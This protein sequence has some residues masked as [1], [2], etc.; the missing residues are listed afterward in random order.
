MQESWSHDG[1]DASTKFAQNSCTMPALAATP[2]RIALD[3]RSPA[4]IYR[5]IYGRIRGA[6]LSGALPAGARLPSWN[7]LASE[8]GVARGTVRAAYDWLAGEG[9]IRAEG[10]AGT[11]VNLGFGPGAREAA[12]KRR[13]AG[14]GARK[15]GAPRDA[16][17]LAPWGLPPRPF[18]VGMPALDAFPRD[19]WTRLL[20]RHAR[21]LAPSMMAYPDPAGDPALREAI[22]SYLAVAR[23][24][25]CARGQ[26]FITAGYTGALDLITRALL[27]P[28]DAAW[29]EDPGYPRGRDALKLAGASLV[30]VPVDAEGLIVTRGIAAAP[31]ARF[32]VVTASHHAPL[33]MP[34]SLSR[35]LALLGWASES[36]GWIIED[37]YYGE[38]QFRGR[39]VPA[40]KSLDRGD[41]V[42]YVGTFSKVLMP[43][44]RLGY[45][46]APAALADRLRR[47]ASLLVP[48]Q[49]L[50]AQRAV[51][52]FLAEGH[53]ARHIR[54]MRRIYAERRAALVEALGAEFGS[55]WEIGLQESGMHLLAHLPWGSDD[56]ALVERAA[57]EGLGPVALSPW[58]IR[59]RPRPGLLIGFA[60]IPAARAARETARLAAALRSGRGPR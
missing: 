38:F 31:E 12:P 56:A 20:A 41:R 55:A 4:P 30:P 16:V 11:R 22:M 49:S 58:S 52:A 6:I 2:M 3:P 60:N 29:F 44:L 43:S 28:G 47:V 34:L 33:G 50:T 13:E 15:R 40:L 36:Q 26:V 48:S 14:A 18:Q 1:I 25:D 35:R 45:V 7:A 10:A 9:Y 37:D 54:R 39:P 21:G 46:V 5:Q 23:G 19:L 53:F 59:A 8:L 24:V 32:A 51:A 17:G 42:L 57:A 27:R